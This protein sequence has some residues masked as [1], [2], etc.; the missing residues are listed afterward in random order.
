LT[1]GTRQD[2]CGSKAGL[3]RDL[4]LIVN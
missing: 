3:D 4:L 1:L 2:T